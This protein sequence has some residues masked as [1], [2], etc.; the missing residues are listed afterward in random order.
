MFGDASVEELLGLG[1]KIFVPVPKENGNGNALPYGKCERTVGH[2]ERSAG[3]LMA[4]GRETLNIAVIFIGNES[5]R[6]GVRPPS[7]TRNCSGLK[8]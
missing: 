1:R 2:I 5:C 3:Q 8:S 7:P 4:S 6:Y